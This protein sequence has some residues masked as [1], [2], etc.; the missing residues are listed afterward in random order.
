MKLIPISRI[1]F[2]FLFFLL[3]GGIHAQELDKETVKQL[4]ESKQFTFHAQSA[5]PLSGQ[6]R[7]L[8]SEYDLKLMI[9]SLSTYL[10]YFGRAYNPPY[11]GEGGIKFS[12]TE[13]DYKA[14]A[15]KKGNWEISISPRD[16]RDVRQMSLSISSSGYASLTV[17]S[18]TRQ[19]IS[20]YGYITANK[21]R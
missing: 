20:F 1:V 2:S 9:D 8:T 3:A 6:S 21:G 4:V 18:N 5:Q 14:K 11:P 12:S 16:N 7:Q 15:K 10:P 13:F 17:N 19:P